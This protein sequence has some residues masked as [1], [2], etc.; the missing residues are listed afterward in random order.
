MSE[1]SSPSSKSSVSGVLIAFA[2]VSSFL[3]LFDSLYGSLKDFSI[4]L[5][6]ID[7]E[8]DLFSSRVIGFFFVGDFYA[9]LGVVLFF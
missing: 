6:L 2:R 4:S 1:D 7:D 9:S 8:S 3:V 5:R